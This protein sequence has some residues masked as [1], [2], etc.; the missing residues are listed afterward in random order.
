[1]YLYF[2]TISYHPE[3]SRELATQKPFSAPCP[4]GFAAQR[5]FPERPTMFCHYETN[6]DYKL[7]ELISML[8]HT[9]CTQ[10]FPLLAQ[11]EEQRHQS[12]EVLE[13][14]RMPRYICR[15]S[16]E[17]GA[18]TTALLSALGSMSTPASFTKM[19][20]EG[21]PSRLGQASV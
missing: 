11:G 20:I 5:P 19:T 8:T 12:K 13:V 2:A 1:M 7:K 3:P 15:T 17:V 4:P 10:C 21:W 16:W 9:R 14:C 6:L 18:Q